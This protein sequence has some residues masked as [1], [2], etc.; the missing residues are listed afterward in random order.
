M[1]HAATTKI[2]GSRGVDEA[3]QNEL[4][5]CLTRG[6]SLGQQHLKAYSKLNISQVETLLNSILRE[7]HANSDIFREFEARV[8]VGV[9]ARGP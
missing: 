9:H 2:F 7:L 5:A 3:R 8:K 6:Q 4:G 1:A